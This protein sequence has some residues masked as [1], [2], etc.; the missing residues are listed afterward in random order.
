MG[1]NELEIQTL[2]MTNLAS[3]VGKY[4]DIPLQLLRAELKK[5]ILPRLD[6]LGGINRKGQ[7]FFIAEDGYVEPEWKDMVSIHYINTSYHTNGRVIR[8]HVFRANEISKESYA[9]CFTL[10]MINEVRIMLSFIYPNWSI[11]NWDGNHLNVMSYLK[12]VHISGREIS[13]YTYPLFVQDNI[14]VTCA[15]ACLISMSRYLHHKYDYNPIRLL[16]INEA[17]HSEKTKLFPSPG[18][19][20]KQMLE[21]L[22]HYRVSVGYSVYKG[23]DDKFRECIDYSLESGLPVI[24]GVA[25]EADNQ[26]EVRHV[27]QM[28][29]HVQNMEERTYVIYDDS[30]CY[31][32]CQ[33]N[34][35][36]FVAAVTWKE[37]KKVI[38]PKKSFIIY[39][40]HDRVYILYDNFKQNFLDMINRVEFYKR[41]QEQGICDFNA[42]RILLADNRDVK[43]FLNRQMN[44]DAEFQ[45]RNSLDEVVRLLERDSPHYLWYC[46]V[47][48]KDA[49][50]IFLADPT[51]SRFTTRNIFLN[52][53]SIIVTQ[54]LSLLNYGEEK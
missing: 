13:F 53:F 37:L 4:V 35:S 49:Y 20:P 44:E 30:G 16:D 24:L 22:N 18:L 3:V 33:E 32:K 46:E 48:L 23:D 17:F 27:I 10:R 19:G 51:Y 2:N 15:Q 12:T 11:V 25:L 6:F 36:G 14:T 50:M 8:V 7:R 5:Y 38:K 1:M 21:I 42:A 52:D 9:G 40:I 39:P 43:S 45:N 28:I 54:Q 29:G 41:L 34:E 47:K 26:R 31:I